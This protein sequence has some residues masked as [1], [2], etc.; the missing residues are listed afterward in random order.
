MIASAL[1]RGDIKRGQIDRTTSG[2]T[3]IA[4]AMIAQLMNMN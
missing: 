3:G 2:N 1:E 4:L